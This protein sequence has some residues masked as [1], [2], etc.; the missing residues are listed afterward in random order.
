MVVNGPEVPSVAVM[1]KTSKPLAATVRVPDAP[2]L[3]LNAAPVATNAPELFAS[4][5]AP[6]AV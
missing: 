6:E 4:D 5:P 2:V 1:A 3:S